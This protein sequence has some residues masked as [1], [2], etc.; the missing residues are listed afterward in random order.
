MGFFCTALYMKGTGVLMAS[1]FA[2]VYV[3]ATGCCHSKTISKFSFYYRCILLKVCPTEEGD[4][5]LVI[6]GFISLVFAIRILN[7]SE[8]ILN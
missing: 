1:V 7:F 6:H 2:A 8:I 4:L 5:I 3:A